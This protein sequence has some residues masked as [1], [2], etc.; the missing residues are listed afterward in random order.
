MMK[1]RLFSMLVSFVVV[2]ACSL[3]TGIP[4]ETSAPAVETFSPTDTVSLPP[5]STPIGGPAQSTAP[6][7]S[8]TREPAATSARIPEFGVMLVSE[9]DVLNVRSGPGVDNGIIDTLDPHAT[10]ITM[11]AHRQQVGNSMWVEIE[12]PSGTLGWV[13]AHFLTEIV[14]VDSFCGDPRVTA[15]IDNFISAIQTRDGDLASQFVNPTHGLTMRVNWWN[16]EVNFA[17]QEIN[18]IFDN[19]TVYDWGVQDGSGF[20]IQGTFSDEVL[21]WMD[22]VFSEPFTP[23][24]N[25]L[26]NGSGPSAGFII[27]PYEYQNINYVALYRSAPAD[28][29]FDWRTWAIGITYHQGQPYITFL[30]QYHWEI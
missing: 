24:C 15:L 25:D 29:E 17:A 18:R 2:M 14:G 19:P 13:N 22:D 7:P 4:T 23:H 12:T 6:P 28:Q 16:P 26:E 3:V 21:P 30:V 9:G 5:T 27:W 10:G 11:T 8:P 1:L 20:P